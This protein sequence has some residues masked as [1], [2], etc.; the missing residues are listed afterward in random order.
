[1]RA[2]R[3]WIWRLVVMAEKEMRQLGR[4]RILLA[5]IVYA[6]TVDIFL[7]ASGVTM[8][9]SNAATVLVD[10]DRSA[11]SRE[12]ASRFQPPYFRQDGVPRRSDDAQRELDNG[13]AMIALD[14]PPNFEADLANGRQTS[15][16]MQVDTTNSVLGFMAAS[17]GARIVGAFGLEQ[18]MAR[19]GL[20][21]GG[22][23]PTVSNEFRVWFNQDQND[24]WFMGI[25]ELL[26][27]VTVF[28]ILL[29]AAAMVREKERGTIEQ[30]LVS[31]L[32][33][34]QILLPKVLAMTTV[35]V[36]G[37]VLALYGVL[38]PLFDV[39]IHGSAALFFA[40]TALYTFTTAGLGLFVATVARNLA[41]AAMLS[42]LIL[43]PVLFLSGTWT[44]PEA[45]PYWLAELMKVSP[46][47]Y[48]LDASFGVLLK[49]QGAQELWRSI[50][51][52]LGI[53]VVVFGFGLY[54]FRRQFG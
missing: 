16:Q 20:G 52:M 32:S 3:I 41:Q 11:T 38:V 51:G 26:N 24:S 47:H 13:K 50:A 39:P 28:A 34:V 49:G 21:G 42:I 19:L 25:A 14:V 36:A 12:L 15:V 40:L 45:L 43:A 4:D 53:G 2:L 18:A 22:E 46:L 35:I 37:A 9:L 29:P 27:I 48:F 6:F 23:L 33:S 44:P 31:P 5:F 30:L 8:Q 1:M 10:S 17:Y 7:A 54:R